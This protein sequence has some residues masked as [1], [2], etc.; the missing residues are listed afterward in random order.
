MLEYN[1]LITT[2]QSVNCTQLYTINAF[3]HIFN[4]NGAIIADHETNDWNKRLKAA[5]ATIPIIQIC[6]HHQNEPYLDLIRMGN[7]YYN[8]LFSLKQ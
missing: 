2:E 8:D 6:K 5:K 4:Y 7:S 3:N 1:S